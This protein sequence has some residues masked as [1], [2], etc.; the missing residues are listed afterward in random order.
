[1]YCPTELNPSDIA[2]RGTKSSEIVPNDLWWKGAP[3][4]VREEAE[5][6]KLPN[7]PISRNT[8]QEEANKELKKGNN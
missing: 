8:V 4:L 5:W 2:S 3:F 6:P 1:M 7:N